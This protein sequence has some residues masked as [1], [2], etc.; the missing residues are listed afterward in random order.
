MKVDALVKSL[1]LVLANSGVFVPST[2][3]TSLFDAKLEELPRRD[4]KVGDGDVT[5][6]KVA[7]HLTGREFAILQCIV[8]GDSNKHIARHLDIAEATVKVHVKGILRKFSVRNRTQAAIWAMSH[9]SSEKQEPEPVSATATI[10]AC[11][12]AAIIGP[13]ALLK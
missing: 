3:L 10:N 1:E 2:I 4:L 13:S 11:D 12:A 7:H 6:P 9:L 8:R 5:S